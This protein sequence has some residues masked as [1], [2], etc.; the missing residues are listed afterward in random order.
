MKPVDIKLSQEQIDKAVDWCMNVRSHKGK[1]LKFDVNNTSRGVDIMGRLGEIA[2]SEVFGG[3][4]DWSLHG[5]GDPGHDIYIFGKSAQV[6]TSSLPTL[7]FNDENQFIAD[8]AIL[9]QLIG[10][11]TEPQNINNIWRVWGVVSKP[12]FM[13]LHIKKNYGYGER[14]ILQANH[15]K[16]PNE[17]VQIMTSP[18]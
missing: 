15:L 2:A 10:T 13:R 8:V 17:F 4:I 1:D 6:K 11:K 16:S 5:G 9:V 14:L 7:I 18:F 3:E 12:K